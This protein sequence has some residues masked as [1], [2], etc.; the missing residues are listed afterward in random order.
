MTPSRR[1]PFEVEFGRVVT[2]VTAILARDMDETFQ[3]LI[4]RGPPHRHHPKHRAAT[5]AHRI[6]ALC[7]RLADALKRYEDTRWWEPQ[8]HDDP[9]DDIPF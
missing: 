7:R 1:E 5:A 6:V 4:R 9:G 8:E 2:A 3:D